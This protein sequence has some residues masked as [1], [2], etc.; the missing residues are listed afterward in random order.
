MGA[1]IAFPVMD[2]MPDCETCEPADAWGRANRGFLIVV[3]VLTGKKVRVCGSCL[4]GGIPLEEVLGQP[5][6]GYRAAV[7]AVTR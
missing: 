7:G 6:D 4:Q 3:N 2:E 1:E 5:D